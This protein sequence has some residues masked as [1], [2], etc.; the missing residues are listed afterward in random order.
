[1]T[2]SKLNQN[3]QIS[4]PA[5]IRKEWK[6]K[7]GDFVQMEK[8]SLGRLILT[9]VEMRVKQ[10]APILDLE[11]YEKDG[12]D[13]GLL[14]SSLARTPT[15]RAETNRAMLEFKEEARKAREKVHGHS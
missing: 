2:L 6:L 1:M 8:D 14:M 10:D 12:V 7:P 5:A 15:E 13:I 4:L 11:K 3:G 9:P